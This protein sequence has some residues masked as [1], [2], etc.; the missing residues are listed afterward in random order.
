MLAFFTLA[1]VAPNRQRTFRLIV[2]AH[3]VALALVFVGMVWKKSGPMMLGNV[4]LIAG[5]IEGALL[6]GWRL[7]QMPKSQALEFLLVSAVRPPCVLLFEAQVGLVRLAFV[8]LAGLP[9]LV[10]MATQGLIYFDDLAALLVLPFV[11]GAVTGLGLT[12]WAYES[13][14]VRRWGEKLGI[15]G[16]LVY[17]IVGVLAGEHLADWLR[18]LPYGWGGNTVAAL[19]GMHEYNPF[20]VMQFA[21]ENAP[22][23]TANRIGWGVAIGI[24]LA[25]V[26]LARSAMRLQGHFQ[27]EHYRPIVESDRRGQAPVGDAPLTWWA[28]KRVSRYAGTI[29]VWLA[30]GFGILYAAL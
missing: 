2:V 21:M 20:G 13:L 25:V 11:W 18:G 7:T 4:L 27:D 10:L 1:A 9:L 8:T 30:G 22:A 26:L 5:I 19:R 24:A 23:W 17:L 28:V 15:L 12:A 3:V 14:R 6:I 16:I 29:N